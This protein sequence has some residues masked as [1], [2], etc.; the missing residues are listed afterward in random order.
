MAPAI[1]YMK[2]G[3]KLWEKFLLD[4]RTEQHTA[5]DRFTDYAGNEFCPGD[6]LVPSQAPC[7]IPNAI[8][9]LGMGSFYDI[10]P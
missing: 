10:I 9:V 1:F 4:L 8:P 3:R 5:K 7:Y 2:D 6:G